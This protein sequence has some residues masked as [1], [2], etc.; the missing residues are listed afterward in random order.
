MNP[1]TY[2]EAEAL[3]KAVAEKPSENAEVVLCPP[4]VW[5]TD[6]SHK[7]WKGIKFGAQ[8]VFWEEK[9]AFTGE[10][11]SAM[12]KNSKVEY[13]IIGHSERRKNVGETDEMVN[14]KVKAA[15]QAGLKVILCVGES[16]EVR[17][18]GI[19]AAKEFVGNQLKED[20]KDIP[21]SQ[22]SIR[23]SVVIAYEPIWAIS[24]GD[25][26]HAADD[27]KNA[28][29]MIVFIKSLLATCYSLP[30]VPVLYGGSVNGSNAKAF[31]GEKEIDGALVGGASL[32][33][34]EFAKI[35]EAA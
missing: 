11:S 23:D 29:E 17:K 4:F 24:G 35:V 19:E 25:P 8:D 31:L 3:A 18:G 10:V 2:E 1:A 22:F 12:L 7:A 30:A 26:T 6:L 20:L 27:P 16:A 13:V 14:K 28:V 15:L 5:L 33:P 9:G 32:K 34:E 21:N